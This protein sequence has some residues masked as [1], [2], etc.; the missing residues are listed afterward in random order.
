MGVVSFTPRP[1]YPHGK[2][3]PVPFVWE[4]GWAPV[5]FWTRRW[6]EKFSAPTGSRTLEPWSSTCSYSLYRLNHVFKKSLQWRWVSSVLD[7]KSLWIYLVDTHAQRKSLKQVSLWSLTVA[8]IKP[9]WLEGWM[10]W[11]KKKKSIVSI[12]P[13]SVQTSACTLWWAR[14][15][16]LQA[17]WRASSL[18]LSSMRTYIHSNIGHGL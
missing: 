9:W 11:V 14:A 5:P 12:I 16:R 13:F 15:M 17:E 4:A 18:F 7:I 6:R 10:I 8:F 3:P 1:L 2:S